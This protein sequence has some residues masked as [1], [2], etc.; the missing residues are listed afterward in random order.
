MR[1]SADLI[2]CD[3]FLAAIGDARDTRGQF[4]PGVPGIIGSRGGGSASGARSPR[5]MPA[6]APSAYLM[7]LVRPTRAVEF[8]YTRRTTWAPTAQVQID[9]PFQFNLLVQQYGSW[10]VSCF[11][12]TQ[13]V[14]RGKKGMVALS[15]SWHRGVFCTSRFPL[16]PA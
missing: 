6:S 10:C 3:P 1:R 14:W 16:R 7:L 4:V 13:T 12:L 11:C 9:N 5:E 8:S 2:R 15:G